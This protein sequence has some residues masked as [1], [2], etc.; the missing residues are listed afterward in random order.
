MAQL[1]QLELQKDATATG[2]GNELKADL[3]KGITFYIK[4]T[5]TPSATVEIQVLT[6]FNDWVSI[7]SITVSHTT[8][9]IIQHRDGQYLKDR[10]KI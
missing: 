4:G 6:P 1:Q 7:D 8:H 5:S 9:I 3:G 2:N 10:A